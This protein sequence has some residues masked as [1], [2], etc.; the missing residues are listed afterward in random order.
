MAST[1]DIHK[2]LLSIRDTINACING[3]MTFE[4]VTK[5]YRDLH[6]MYEILRKSIENSDSDNLIG[7]FLYH[8]NVHNFCKTTGLY[9]LENGDIRTV[10]EYGDRYLLSRMPAHISKNI[11]DIPA[12]SV[13][14]LYFGAEDDKQ[15]KLYLYRMQNKGK[16]HVLAALS[17]SE[18]F[19][20]KEFEF[21]GRFMEKY[22]F[23]EDG[24]GEEPRVIDFINL[25]TGD[26]ARHIKEYRESDSLIADLY[27]LKNVRI[28]FSHL[29][30]HDIMLLSDEITAS[31][32]SFYGDGIRIIPLSLS[33]YVVLFSEK[34]MKEISGTKKRIDFIFNSI[35]I[36]FSKYRHTIEKSNE[37]IYT[38]FENLYREIA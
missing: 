4:E 5:E 3:N 24:A 28:T 25:I 22:L 32:E 30:I 34:K 31:F 19:Q 12:A 38:F 16:D 7:G 14:E 26:I 8:H 29:G 11:D 36:P 23:S 1:T 6:N 33:K 10:S 9:L 27:I 20:K 37:S 35:T 13:T 17:A 18:Y 21:F 15:M 2:I